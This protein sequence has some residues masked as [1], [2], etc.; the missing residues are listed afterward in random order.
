ML[1]R[2]GE[3]TPPI[4][5]GPGPI[6]EHLGGPRIAVD[7]PLRARIAATGAD[8]IDEPAVLDEASR[9][10]WPLAM[11]WAL[12]AEV[13]ARAA[14]V[15]RPHDTDQVCAVM[16]ACHEARVPVT[17]AAGRSGVCGASVPV[18]GGVVLD[19]TGLA[20]IVSVDPVSLL[21][22]VGPGTFG[23]VFEDELRSRYGLTCGHWP[24]SIAL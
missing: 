19:L 18:F 16:R 14:V 12:D 1:S 21:V 9:D 7:G 3:P 23:D 5:F 24:Q 2:R 20:G 17:A 6:R 13:A 4:A 8:V 22:E 10:W 15:V 11:I